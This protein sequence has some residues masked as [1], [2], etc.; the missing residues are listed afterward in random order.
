MTLVLALVL[1]ACL[2]VLISLFRQ[3]E[4]NRLYG[5][6][7]VGILLLAPDLSM[8]GF[9]YGWPAWK[10]TS[11]GLSVSPLT[12]IALSLLVTHRKTRGKLSFWPLFAFYGLTLVLSI[13]PSA[14][15]IGTVFTWWQFASVLVI[16]AAIASECH[17]S[18]VRNSI[19]NGLSIGLVY[20]AGQVVWQ[21]ASG[22]VQAAGTFGHQN[23]LGLAIELSVV[24]LIALIL[25]G[26]K[27]PLLKVGVVAALVCVGG[28]GSRATVAIAGAAIVLLLVLSVFLRSTPRKMNIVG[29]AFVGLL[30]ATPLA[31][32]TLNQRFGDTQITTEDAGR[33]SME[34]TATL[35]ANDH[36][37]GVGANQYVPTSIHGGYADRAGMSWMW[38]IRNKPVHNAYM[39]ARAE[40]GYLGQ[41]AFFLMLLVPIIAAFR[42]A[43]RNRRNPIGELALGSAV[44]LTANALHNNY[45]FAVHTSAILPLLFFNIGMVAA[46]IRHSAVMRRQARQAARERR[47]LAAA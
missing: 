11:L 8:N 42:L 3:K 31:L 24:P 26:N 16:F 7:A 39:L 15:K 30:V 22:V 13:I 43:F 9:L 19:A 33:D 44:A 36:P 5:V 21:K 23:I 38:T 17:R 14:Q 2:P 27:S 37:F 1:L 20:Q 47:A 4:Q 18:E 12:V 6:A 35:M 34:R 45:E 10:G 29:F 25:S 40:T 46:L 32:G 28:S 41:A